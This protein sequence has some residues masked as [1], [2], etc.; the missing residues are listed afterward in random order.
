[1]KHNLAIS[2]GNGNNCRK[3]IEDLLSSSETLKIMKG[4]CKKFSKPNCDYKIFN[5][6]NDLIKRRE[7]AI[8]KNDMEI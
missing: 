2:I 6:I 8:M 1:M 4:N 5:V 3:K 7:I